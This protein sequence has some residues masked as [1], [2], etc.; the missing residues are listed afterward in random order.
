MGNR[1]PSLPR[2]IVLGIHVFHR[3]QDELRGIQAHG[4]CPLWRAQILAR[5]PG[6][7]LLDL[8]DDGT[9]RLN[10]D[11]FNYATG[12]TMTNGRFDDLFGGPP[13]SRSHQ[14]PSGRWTSR[15]PSRS[16]PRRSSCASAAA[17]TVRSGWIC[18]ALPG[19]LRLTVSPTARSSGRRRTRIS[20]SSPRLGMPAVP[21][22]RRCPSGTST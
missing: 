8:K 20:G 16:S 6:E 11:Y 13:A 22:A 21:W 14:S 15:A 18:Y 2:A 5:D 17:Y 10:M 1:F 3:F 19:A 4:A 7:P 12:L 9:F